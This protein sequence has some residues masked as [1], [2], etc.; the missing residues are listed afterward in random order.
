MPK[1]IREV[2][3][4]WII[5]DLS[6]ATILVI[7][8]NLGGVPNVVGYISF[9]ATVSSLILAVIAIIYSIHQNSS[10]VTTIS[11]LTE[12]ARKIVDVTGELDKVARQLD[13][14]SKE[15]PEAVIGLTNRVVEFLDKIPTSPSDKSEWLTDE[16]VATLMGK[17][18][19]AMA[20]SYYIFKTAYQRPN[21]FLDLRESVVFSEEAQAAIST[22]IAMSQII[23]IVNIKELIT[24][25]YEVT[26]IHPAIIDKVDDRLRE[27]LE[28]G[29]E[30]SG[31]RQAT[32]D[33]FND[34]A[35]LVTN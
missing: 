29:V 17:A 27:V 33:K 22:V 16:Q 23:G 20:Y 30:F 10:S 9:A 3:Y 7:T 4:W 32:V 21:K 18:T 19:F 8:A 35:E 24:L 26:Y 15:M 1:T 11:Q 2:N 14:R 5:G 34:S 28:K 13:T 12:S 6:V 25:T 31:P